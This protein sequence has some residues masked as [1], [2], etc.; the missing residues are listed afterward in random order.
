ML[1]LAIVGALSSPLSS[2]DSHV[3]AWSLKPGQKINA[4]VVLEIRS[5][6]PILTGSIASDALLEVTGNPSSQGIPILITIREFLIEETRPEV[7]K[8]LV[9]QTGKP[10]SIVAS[11]DGAKDEMARLAEVLKKSYEATLSVSGVLKVSKGGLDEDILISIVLGLFRARLP[12]AA[13]N[14]KDTWKG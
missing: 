2:Q 10:P 1:L 5:F 11:T 14:V 9:F 4:K 13:A 12:G 3:L 8:K 7:S 6:T